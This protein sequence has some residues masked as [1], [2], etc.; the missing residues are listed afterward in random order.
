MF[1]FYMWNVII[2]EDKEVVLFVVSDYKMMI[3]LI[4]L[5]YVIG[6]VELINLLVL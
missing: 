2:G 3:E 1:W 4:K 6:N 5:F